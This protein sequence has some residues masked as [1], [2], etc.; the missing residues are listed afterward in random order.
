MTIAPY[1]APTSTGA[2]QS[3]PTPAA[4]PAATPTSFGSPGT[5]STIS[6]PDQ[7]G[8]NPG[9]ITPAPV[10]APASQG[11]VPQPGTESQTLPPNIANAVLPGGPDVGGTAGTPS[12]P[13]SERELIQAIAEHLEVKPE[14]G[15]NLEDS[16]IEALSKKLGVQVPQTHKGTGHEQGSVGQTRHD[17]A[18]W[19]DDAVRDL[20]KGAAKTKGFNAKVGKLTGQPG[21][22]QAMTDEFGKQTKGSDSTV[23]DESQ[24]AVTAMLKAVDKKLGINAVPGSGGDIADIAKGLGVTMAT[25]ALP[26]TTGGQQTAA[27]AYVAFTKGAFSNGKLTAE[28]TQWA[29]DLENS[30]YLD[31]NAN[32]SAP[33]ND[34]IA[35]AYQNL[36]TDSV[37]KK[38]SLTAAMQA[39][40]A[41][42]EP[43]GGQTGPTSEMTSYVQGVASEFGI[44]LTQAQIN[45]IANKYGS[46]ALTAAS[47][48]SVEDE[49]K[50]AAVQ[51]YDPNNPN[52]PPGVANTMFTKIQQAA[53]AYQIP[54]SDQAIG[55]MV[56]NALQGATVE[57]MY[58]AADAA[59][60]QATQLF[61]AQAAGL[62]PTL[63]KQIEAGQDVQTLVAP[64]YQVAEQYT[65][66]PASTMMT[67]GGG[68]SGPSKWGAFL[69][70]GTDPKTGAPTTQTL[71]QWKKTLM[72]DPQY[73]FQKTQGAKDMAAQFS[74]AL[75]NEFGLVS[76]QSSSTPFSGYSNTPGSANTS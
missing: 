64:Y 21:A 53:L 34:Q 54:I 65:G 55:T 56:K 59:A 69:Q 35:A 45:D 42:G 28:G 17:I 51:Y 71:D 48:S 46:T 62:Y 47:P 61:Q 63:A 7:A 74:S 16:V 30:N 12:R 24:S 76:T 58:V 70:G 40:G 13:Y 38:I 68:T 31:K 72:Q 32:N 50:Q 4:T 3:T 36:L 15:K 25:T 49:I 10:T 43:P 33:T 8:L 14:K 19:W 2:A 23:P 75:L 22:A 41:A 27:Q 26:G 9:P 66:V 67:E 20:D 1:E 52:N 39:K 60:A 57:S 11:G 6:G 37:T 44:G 73:G 5:T 29:T 18:S